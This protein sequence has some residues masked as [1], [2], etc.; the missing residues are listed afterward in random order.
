[1]SDSLAHPLCPRLQ[2]LP[3]WGQAAPYTSCS[4]SAS[5]AGPAREKHPFRKCQ[6]SDS[7]GRQQ[8]GRLWQDSR[9]RG[10]LPAEAC[11]RH[12]CLPGPPAAK[13][14]PKARDYLLLQRRELS[15]TEEC[16]TWRRE[17]AGMEP[18]LPEP[19]H[20]LQNKEFRA[21]HCRWQLGQGAKAKAFTFSVM[22]TIIKSAQPTPFLSHQAPL[23][24]RHIPALPCKNTRKIHPTAQQP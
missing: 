24:W 11:S 18:S 4:D 5:W 10:A 2:P 19:L 13:A 6:R 3:L 7:E 17:R 8:R 22:H 14:W 21:L 23:Y 20:S 1:M 12:A 16:D 9:S 15:G